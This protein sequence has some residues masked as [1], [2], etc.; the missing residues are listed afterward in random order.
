MLKIFNNDISNP[1]GFVVTLEL[2]PKRES[3]GVSTDTLIG[4]AKD[5]FTDG[6][7]SAVSITDNPGGNPSLSPDV[8]GYQI[9]KHGM[10]VIV[11]FTCR[12]MNRVGM[13]S[14][15][16]Q[17]AR[18]GMKNI[19]A[20][21]GDYSGKGFGGQG[22]P[23]FDFDSVILS[24][25]LKKLNQ[26]LASSGDPDGFF[27]GCA[28][29]PFKATKAERQIQYKKLERKID[30]GASFVITQLGYDIDKFQELINQTKI[31][32]ITTPLLASVY[33]L[34]PRSARAMNRGRVPG[35]TVSDDLSNQIVSEWENSKVEGLHKAIERA[36]KL[37]VILKGIGYRGIHLGGIHRSFKSV[38][39]ILD[40]MAMFEHNWQDY[41]E[42]FRGDRKKGHYISEQSYNK[43]SID[44]KDDNLYSNG[45]DSS[46]KEIIKRKLY[47]NLFD[48]YPYLLLKKAHEIFFDKSSSLA[49]IYKAAAEVADKNNKGWLLKMLLEDPLKKLFLSCRSC[50]DCGI[51]HIAFQCPES[52]CPKHTRNGPCGGSSNGFCEVDKD[53]KCI[54]VKA[55]NRLEQSH[56]TDKL[57][58]EF[59]LP[60]MWE[61]NN[62]SSWINFHLDRDHQKNSSIKS[63][64]NLKR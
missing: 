21:T 43:E 10:D 37:A 46:D 22:A 42:E 39:A 59:V 27:T 4:I 24:A 49:P 33:M 57:L 6:R 56:Q 34:S 47:D 53:K 20:L 11:H 52:G 19:L 26:R 36:A 63:T 64:D 62:T 35:V 18:M 5:A 31:K 16:L 61:L 12:D 9:F 32:G 8:L 17:L 14:R 40:K 58:Q 15:A 1:D 41:L 54:W 29:S 44:E 3:I 38:G 7:I 30:A 45:Y 25:M 51:V 50:G 60:R 2:V 23:V 28:V 55:W 13:E 48:Y